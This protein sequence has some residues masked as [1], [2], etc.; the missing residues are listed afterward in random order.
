MA[1]ETPKA[2]DPKAHEEHIYKLWEESG[3]FNPDK[4]PDDRPESFT[5]ALPPP[6]ITGSLHMGHALNAAI[7]DILI[8]TKRMQ[9]YKTLWIPGTDHASIATQNVI[10]KE[11]R[12]EGKTRHDLGREKFIERFWEWKEKYGNIILEQLKKLGA[13]CDWS[14][15]RFTMDEGYTA[16]VEAAFRYYYEKGWVYKG[17]RVVSW[18][19][20]CQTS[21]SDLEVEY[22]DEQ[23]TLSYITYG[24]LTLA[25]VRPETKL[26]DTALAVHPK[27]ERYASYV[28]KML[29]IDSVSTSGE[30]ETPALEKI[31]IRVVADEAVDPDFGTGVVKVTPAHDATDFEIA[32][33]HDISMRQVIDAYG[34]MNELAGK[35]RGLKVI[36]AR[37]K[38][39]EDLKT[40]GL[41]EK[42]EPYPH[43]VAVC[44]RCSTVIE[45]LPSEQWYVRM[46]E[47]ASLAHNAVK[48]KRVRFHPDRWEGVYT[49]WLENIKDWC[50]SRQIWLGHRIP[51]WYCLKNTQ[52]CG[53]III[54]QEKPAECQSC[55]GKNLEPELDT[56]DTWFS[57]AL[58][59][60]ATL[61]WPNAQGQGSKVK[62]QRWDLESF[63][64]TQV[65]STARDIINLWVARMVFSGVAFMGR[66]PFRDVIV[67]ATVLAKDGRRMSKSL[68]TGVDPLK[69]IETYGAD[70]TRFG[71][72][73]MSLG[74]QDMKFGEEPMVAGKKFLNKIW[75]AARFVTAKTSGNISEDFPEKPMTLQNASLIEAVHDVSAKVTKDIETYEFGQA[76]HALHDFFWHT[77]CDQ[78]VEWAKKSLDGARDGQDDEETKQTL[79]A[80]LVASLKLLHPFIPFVTEALWQQIRKDD[81]PEQ[82][83]IAEWPKGH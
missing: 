17:K 74:G 38:I 81:W 31:T 40:L 83:I 67:H 62:G 64:P 19:T 42:E 46:E 79:G 4:L 53:E 71:L 23:G 55:G 1:D 49:G 22:R 29:E 34:R 39:S 32:E 26:G 78:Y 7:Q 36:E 9:G 25:T 66:E 68:G 2:Y 15:T 51:V 45:P 58:W 54:S 8:R 77:F 50:I 24:P 30:L 11:L 61:G 41:L 47:L 56:F 3:C 63:Y 14:R 70:A 57:S 59:P 21:L 20:R 65:L 10:E 52:G 75:N 44:Y 13:S 72:I 76:L 18:C 82:L 80:T 12:K 27:D 5:I 33:R 69:L 48:E 73:W 43:R 35:Y 16:A 60:F 28:G 6:N 37:K